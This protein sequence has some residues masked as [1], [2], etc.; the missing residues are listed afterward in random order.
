MTS[1][2]L[3]GQYVHYATQTLHS[4]TF[5]QGK[6]DFKIVRIVVAATVDAKAAICSYPATLFLP[7]MLKIGALLL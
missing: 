3:G 6:A 5:V 4:E 1:Q 7:C 2:L